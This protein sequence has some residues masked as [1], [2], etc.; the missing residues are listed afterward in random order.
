[1][2]TKKEWEHIFKEVRAI[3]P[4]PRNLL[5]RGW[6]SATEGDIGHSLGVLHHWPEGVIAK[7]ET[8]RDF[9][10]GTELDNF[11]KPWISSKGDKNNGVEHNCLKFRPHYPEHQSWY[12]FQCVGFNT[13][14]IC[15]YEDP[16]IL[17]LR[18]FCSGTL[19]EHERYA[20]MQL[21]KDPQK[22]MMIGYQSARIEHDQSHD[23]WVLRDSRQNITARTQAGQLS[24]ALGKHNWTISGDRYHCSGGRDY[25]I[26]MKSYVNYLKTFYSAYKI[27]IINI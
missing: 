1:M 9:Y 18:G 14:C 25:T 20:V 23:Q 2:R 5:P 16:P 3:S 27:V 26:E 4:D 8:W 17:H 12:E 15:E 10:S 21:P 13:G 7:E 11:T 22:I 6:L 24:F 19:V